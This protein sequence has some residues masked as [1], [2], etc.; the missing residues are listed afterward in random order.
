MWHRTHMI[1]RIYCRHHAALIF[2]VFLD[3]LN[4]AAEAASMW[5]AF[6]LQESLSD[7]AETLYIFPSPWDFSSNVNVYKRPSGPVLISVMPRK[8]VARVTA[9]TSFLLS[10]TLSNRPE[11]EDNDDDN[12]WLLLLSF[13][14]S[15]FS[16]VL[17]SLTSK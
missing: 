8:P 2:L 5:S 7:A 14:L 4:S 12:C 10:A 9:A 11:E 17:F 6:R 16:P 15:N 1:Q 13:L 3:Y